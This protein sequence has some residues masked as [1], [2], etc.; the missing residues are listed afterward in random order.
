M[1]ISVLQMVIM[2]SVCVLSLQ[3]TAYL[4]KDY[5]NLWLVHKPDDGQGETK[6]F[7]DVWTLSTFSFTFRAFRRRFFIQ[8][9]LQKVL[10]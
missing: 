1:D 4:H 6:G 5:N 10:L 9:N 7:L 3:V 8:S 2:S